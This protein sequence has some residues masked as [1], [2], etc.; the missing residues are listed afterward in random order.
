MINFKL[1]AGKKILVTGGAGFIGSNLC[2][3]LLDHKVEVSCLD[4]YATGKK[5]NIEHLIK[6]IHDVRKKEQKNFK[7]FGFACLLTILIFYFLLN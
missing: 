7:L 6:R 5:K 1:L 2:E 4:N 3:K